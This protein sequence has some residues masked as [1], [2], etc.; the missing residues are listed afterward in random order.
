[1]RYL[2]IFKNLRKRNANCSKGGGKNAKD[3]L[4]G[5][6]IG[7]S[8]R[9]V[10]LERLYIK[11]FYLFLKQILMWPLAEV[12]PTTADVVYQ[13]RSEIIID[14]HLLYR[15]QGY[16]EAGIT[17]KTANLLFLIPLIEV[18]YFFLNKS[19]NRKTTKLRAWCALWRKTSTS[20][21]YLTCSL[22]MVVV[23]HTSTKRT[24]NIILVPYMMTSGW[25]SV[26]LSDCL[27]CTTAQ[28]YI[29]RFLGNISE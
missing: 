5:V 1:M 10:P 13:I 15:S 17:L 28:I 16:S 20:P 22:L 26:G 6:G 7:C 24:I 29:F 25:S 21:S 19:V 27:K 18:K 11:N 3:Y 14:L 2:M 4:I 9:A 12:S 23:A 8:I